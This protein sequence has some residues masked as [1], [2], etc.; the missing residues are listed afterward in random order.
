MPNQVMRLWRK[1]GFRRSASDCLHIGYDRTAQRGCAQSTGAADQCGQQPPNLH[2][3]TDRDRVLV[4]L[5]LFHVGGLNISLTPALLCRRDRTSAR[6]GSIRRATLAAVEAIRPHIL[7]LVPATMMAVMRQPDWL[8]GRGYHLPKNVDDGVH[9]WCPVE[10]IAAYED[11]GI[12]VV[13]VYGSTET[14]PI[15]A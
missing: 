2:K 12:S 13:Q 15:A 9:W 5:P 7:V 6:P 14:C 1:A 8:A 11:K 4:V 3:L 10:L